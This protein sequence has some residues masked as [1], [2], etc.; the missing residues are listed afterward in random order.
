MQD[1]HKSEN[2]G[3]PKISSASPATHQDEVVSIFS[4]VAAE[5]SGPR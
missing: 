5:I 4:V 3:V 2:D 1:D